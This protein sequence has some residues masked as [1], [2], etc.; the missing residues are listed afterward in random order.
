[1]AYAQ[2]MPTAAQAPFGEHAGTPTWLRRNAVVLTGLGLIAADLLWKWHLLAHFFFRQNDFQWLD[3]ARASGFTWP[4]LTTVSGGHLMPGARAIAWLVSRLPFYDWTL[5]SAV[6]LALL[7][8]SCL[9]LLALL[10]TLFGDRLQILILLLVYLVTPLTLP[11]LAFW[12]SMVTWLPLQT[13][14]FLAV[15]AH[16]RYLRTGRY[17]HAVAAAAFLAAGMLLDDQGALVPFLLLA[18]TSGFF[19]GGWWLQALGGA[20]RRWAGAWALYGVLT[21]GYLVFFFTR[22]RAAHQLPVSPGHGAAHFMS[23]ALEVSFIPAA[24]GGPW[25][26]FANDGYAV[27]TQVPLLTALSWVVAAAIIVVSL[28]YR[29]HAWRAWAILAAWLL[30]AD[31]LPVATTSSGAFSS[32]LG[33]DLQYLA[34]S[35]GILA[36]C[37]GLA[38]WPVAGEGERDAYRAPLPPLAQRRLAVYCLMACILAGGLWSQS[39]YVNDTNSAAVSSYITTATASL[40]QAPFGTV[41]ISRPVPSAVMNTVLFGSA[42]YTRQVL[43]PL[44]PSGSGLRWAVSP[45]GVAQHLMIFDGQGRLASAV[46]DGPQSLTAAGPLGCWPVTASGLHVPVNGSL[47]KWYWT[48]QLWYSGPASTLQVSYGGA[49]ATI[50][51]PAGTHDVYVPVTG[52][53]NLVVIRSAGSGPSACVSHLTVGSLHPAAGAA[54]VASAPGR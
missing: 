48:V 52:G 53:G 32:V 14:I 29:R 11:G 17:R 1:M 25:H 22:L 46:I 18:V 36:I 47:Y 2:R 44:A 16:V 45:S 6:T 41:I 38:F 34:D 7:A 10:R 4:Y 54:S 40:R 13:A 19:A 26:W 33:W 28:W 23:V 3:T 37:V 42:A 50:K 24:L 51:V 21:A 39:S 49:A 15:A 5:T 9:A 31:L 43:G 8:A 27:A 35:A 12:S 20:V 30:I